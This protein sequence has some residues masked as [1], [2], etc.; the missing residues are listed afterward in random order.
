[1][2]VHLAHP[3]Q[4]DIR[5]NGAGQAGKRPSLLGAR[6]LL[7]DEV[8]RSLA[9]KPEEMRWLDVARAKTVAQAVAETGLDCLPEAR[10]STMDEEILN[11]GWLPGALA[12]A[13]PSEVVAM[14][15]VA[16]EMLDRMRNPLL[17]EEAD[18][19]PARQIDRVADMDFRDEIRN[20]DQSFRCFTV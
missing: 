14:A 20:E 11:D 16:E 17:P 3:L 4:C 15:R 19:L 18:L 5:P 2:L 6:Q 8:T 12:K 1:M 13:L 7:T 9:G 10:P